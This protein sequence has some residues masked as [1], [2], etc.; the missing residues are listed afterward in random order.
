MRA[1]LEA[2][3]GMTLEDADRP[4]LLGERERG[5]ETG[6][7]PANNSDVDPLHE[8][9]SIAYGRVVEV[10][11]QEAVEDRRVCVHGVCEAGERFGHW[12]GRSENVR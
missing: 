1:R 11:E 10:R 3:T 12:I 2:G 7:A 5:S 6:H 9:R 4:A 8:S